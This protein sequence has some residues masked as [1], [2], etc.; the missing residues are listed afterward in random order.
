[1]T[2]AWTAAT[3]S[4]T[5]AASPPAIPIT[6]APAS[7]SP[8]FRASCNCRLG[9]DWCIDTVEVRLVIRIELRATFD[10]SGWRGL[11]R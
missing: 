3:A 4:R 1:M 8:T 7:V 6:I 9:T 5:A 2:A 11:W 10:H